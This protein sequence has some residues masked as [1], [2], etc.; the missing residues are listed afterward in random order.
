VLRK[1]LGNI[2]IREGIHSDND[3][4]LNLT[5]L[6]PMKGKISIIID[7]KPD[8]F[9]LLEMRGPSIVLIAEI[10][11]EIIGSFSASAVNVFVNERPEVIYYLADFKVHPDYQKST[12]AMRLAKAM[13]Q[14]LELKN[15]D[16]VYCTVAQG[17][18]TVNPFLKGRASLQPFKEMGIFK[19]LQIIPTPF[20]N[21][22]KKYEIN[23][24]LSNPSGISYFGNFMKKY[25]LGPFYINKSFENSTLITASLNNK[26]VSAIILSDTG[27]A[28]Q[29]VLIKLPLY[30]KILV[31]IL[32]IINAIVP[33]IILPKINEPIRILYI[34]S[35]A[36]EPGYEDALRFL[37]GRARRIAFE[38]KFMFLTIGIHENDPKLKIFSRYPKFVFKSLGLITSLKGGKDKI[39]SV[40]NGIP[41]EDYSLV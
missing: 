12:V 28:K 34:K 15:A 14:K 25:Q 31:K 10:N 6:A 19:V 35:F 21:N 13:Q 37:L 26:V 9:K 40:L 5:S 36:Y 30:L 41:F 2:I 7:R 3:G 38:K 17:N 16:L 11:N 27:Q 1:E 39:H 33:I 29:N 32:Q 20:R 24:G 23:E 18:I 22:S 8:F 4:I